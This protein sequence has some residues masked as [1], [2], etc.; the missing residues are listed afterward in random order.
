MIT[1]VEYI[2]STNEISGT[3]TALNP[4]PS[5]DNFALADVP[6]GFVEDQKVLWK[7]NNGTIIMKTGQDLIN[8]QAAYYGEVVERLIKKYAFSALNPVTIGSLEAA[9][10]IVVQFVHKLV[11]ASTSIPASDKEK[12]NAFYY[13]NADLF[14]LKLENATQTD[15]YEMSVLKAA[16]RQI[17]IDMKDDPEWPT[18]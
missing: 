2:I 16:A 15:W 6:D 11:N 18:G 4:V 10:D 13:T 7:N 14:K 5:G 1:K 8:A 17:E 12:W 3:V 9:A